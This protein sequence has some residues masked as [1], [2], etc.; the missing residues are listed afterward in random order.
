VS[1]VER[2]DKPPTPLRATRQIRAVGAVPDAE[3][4]FVGALLYS[5]PD[6]VVDV[7]RYVKDDDLAAPA[8]RAILASIREVLT[9]GGAFHPLAVLDRLERRDGP[10]AAVRRALTD[11]TT[12]GAA[13]CPE[14]VRDYA[15]I[16][17]SRSLRR[18]LESGGNALQV[19][20]DQ[21]AEN[22][23]APL[24]D[25]VADTARGIANRL[26]TLRGEAL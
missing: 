3:G 8:L 5:A 26:E 9:S 25:R 16:V 21:G 10:R 23:L 15:V 2:E 4:L 17:V 1:L 14:A 22:G 12:N 11:C 18:C 13:S 19:A 6:E 20:A 7:L 24:A